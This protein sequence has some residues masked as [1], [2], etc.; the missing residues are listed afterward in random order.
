MV[1]FRQMD[2]LL[3]LCVAMNISRGTSELFNKQ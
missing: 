1:R 3:D 2:L